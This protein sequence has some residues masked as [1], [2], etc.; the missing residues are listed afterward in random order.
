MSAAEL[1]LDR[2]SDRIRSMFGRVAHRYDL[3]NHLLSGSLDRLW[4]RRL[5]RAIGLPPGS[6]L[7]DL[8]SGTGDQAQ[9]LRGRGYRV[10]AADFCLPMLTRSRGK[11]ARG[12]LPRPSPLQADALTLPFPSASFDGATVSF[13]LRNVSDLDRALGELAR[14]V[15]AGG[16]LGVLEFTVPVR[17]PMRALYLAYF[18]HLLPAIGSRISGDADAYRYLPESVLGFPQRGRFVERL[19]SAGFREGR[20]MSLSGGI[21]CLYLARRAE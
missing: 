2:E 13:G 18:R 19:E 10:A 11:F 7:L 20:F 5:A 4:R 15:R 9:A 21:L 12:S 14:V 6:R 3:L 8:C 16:V 1:P 17:Q